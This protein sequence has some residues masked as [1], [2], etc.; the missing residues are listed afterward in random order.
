MKTVLF[1]VLT[2]ILSM[3]KASADVEANFELTASVDYVKRWRHK[4]S[5]ECYPLGKADSVQNQPSYSGSMTRQITFVQSG[6]QGI[7]LWVP[8]FTHQ[9]FHARTLTT[10]YSETSSPDG[11]E[12]Q[13]INIDNTPRSYEWSI[14]GSG[15]ARSSGTG[16][17]KL[18]QTGGTVTF[19][20]TMPPGVWAV[21]VERS[22]PNGVFQIV[23]AEIG[24]KQVRTSEGFA[25]AL[26]AKY[27]KESPR[28]SVIWAVPGTKIK[29]TF[30]IPLAVW[31]TPKVGQYT[32]TFRPIGTYQISKSDMIQLLKKM[33]DI[34]PKMSINGP[35]FLCPISE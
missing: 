20:Y 5:L 33:T 28:K 3:E 6:S 4:K 7:E 2:I 31:G 25:N 13:S 11:T 24:D 21:E 23:D 14:D 35:K 26:N 16:S 34:E 9:P 22:V 19:E 1:I 30:L 10:S 15:C 17:A 29:Q 32:M 18:M 27:D 12:T 8:S